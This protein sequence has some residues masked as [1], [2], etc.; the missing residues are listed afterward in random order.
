[1]GDQ[2]SQISPN[3]SHSL[4]YEV[5]SAVDTTAKY[6]LYRVDFTSYVTGD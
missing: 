5:I 1:M 6:S 2:L 3:A 4:I